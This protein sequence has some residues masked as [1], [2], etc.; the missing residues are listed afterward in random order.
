MRFSKAIL[1]A[2]CKNMVKGITSANL[3]MPYYQVAMKQHARY[4]Q[5]LNQLGLSTVL[6][7]EDNRFP[8]SCFVEDTAV[9]C[10]KI[11]I[12]TLLGE[13][14]RQGEEL[15]IYAT[16]KFYY[17]NIQFIVSPGTVDG[18]DVMRIDNVFYIGLSKRTNHDG[19]TQLKYILEQEGYTIKFIELSHFLHLKS[20]INYLGENTVLAG[21][22]FVHKKEFQKYKIIEVKTN[23]Q[24]S[25]N[26]LRVNSTVIIPKGFPNTKLQLINHGFQIIEINMSEFQKLDGGLSC[27]S[28]RF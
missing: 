23:E 10:D 1:R 3:G 16:L 11:A 25:A 26:S 24:Y 9:L 14:S 19:A 17:N 13:P 5:I 20:G 7:G 12:I 21:G 4:N 6:L 18:G 15:S 27:L 2:P 28:L 8:D 22:E